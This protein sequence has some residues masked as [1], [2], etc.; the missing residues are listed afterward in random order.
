[1]N[2]HSQSSEPCLGDPRATEILDA[3]RKTFAE[4]GFDGASMQDL[5]LAAGM[6]VGNFYRYFRSKA[7]LVE[8]MVAYDLTQIQAVFAMV[9]AA[10]D[11]MAALRGVVSH[12]LRTEERGALYAEI[13]AAALRKP[14]IAALCRK[15]EEWITDRL[16]DVFAH[17]ADIPLEE[18]R[19]R[20]STHAGV[21]VLSVKATAMHRASGPRADVDAVMERLV[22]ALLDEVTG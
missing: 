17:V 16:I 21:I 10:P 9:M 18:A 19:L 13:N 3:I 14:E 11:P 2:V 6:S 8:A 20:F 12:R 22:N 15:Q 5:A 7:G 1:M 4:K